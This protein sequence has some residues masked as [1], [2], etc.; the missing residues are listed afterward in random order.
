MR[1]RFPSLRSNTD[2]RLRGPVA[3]LAIVCLAQA[4]L[5]DRAAAQD[6]LVQAQTIVVAPDT[7]V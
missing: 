5:A 3:T 1:T 2:S 4:W 6:L 7:V